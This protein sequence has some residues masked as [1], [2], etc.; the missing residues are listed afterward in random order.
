MGRIAIDS[1]VI[2]IKEILCLLV[3]TTYVWSWSQDA[4]QQEKLLFYSQSQS[5]RFFNSSSISS[6]LFTFVI[7]FFIYSFRLKFTFLPHF[8]WVT[9]LT[10]RFP[11][12]IVKHENLKVAMRKSISIRIFF[13]KIKNKNVFSLLG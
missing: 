9:L 12:F 13:E 3:K 4:T 8:L 1:R 6:L 2:V 11:F 7:C 10:F 5:F